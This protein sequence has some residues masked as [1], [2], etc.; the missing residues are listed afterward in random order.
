MVRN[1]GV[2]LSGI[3]KTNEFIFE[4]HKCSV[5]TEYSIGKVEINDITGGRIDL[6]LIDKLN[7][8]EI[9]IENKIYANDQNNQLERYCAYASS[10]GNKSKV[11]YL[12]LDGSKSDSA[13]K[14]EADK[15]Y[16]CLSY[17][18]DI[19]DWLVKCHG[20][21][22]DYPIIRETIKQYIISI[23]KLT[24]Q[25]TNNAMEIELMK[26]ILD[27]QNYGAAKQI[28]DAFNQL[29][30]EK[31]K[32]WYEVMD[33]LKKY[34]DEN[35]M[36]WVFNLKNKSILIDIFKHGRGVFNI[37]IQD[38]Y[39]LAFCGIWMNR[40]KFVIEDVYKYLDEIKFEKTWTK[41]SQDE[42]L[43]KKYP[44]EKA[45]NFTEPITLRILYEPAHRKALAK[46]FVDITIEIANN[47]ADYMK[48]I[49]SR[50]KKG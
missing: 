12:T 33:L 9:I 39:G 28:I 40:D 35:H 44:A 47:Y 41:N 14:Y 45:Y 1:R 7:N 24:G 36:G 19:L 46:E 11:F 8:T 5:L 49:N 27:D 20:E 13:G 30:K 4:A 2:C 6:L 25:L 3:S 37:Y 15:D 31:D 10:R 22:S 16:Y 26:K 23:K 43:Y 32:F 21:V 42:Y 50:F 34:S 38:V 17:S 48:T 29:E 18:T